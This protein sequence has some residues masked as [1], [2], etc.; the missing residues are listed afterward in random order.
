MEKVIFWGKIFWM[1]KPNVF[2]GTL[3]QY[4]RGLISWC[5][6]VDGDGLNGFIARTCSSTL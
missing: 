5:P 4:G 1:I 3:K 2:I 6:K